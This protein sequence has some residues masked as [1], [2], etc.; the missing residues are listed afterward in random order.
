MKRNQSGFTLIELLIVIIIISILSL[1]GMVVYAQA[2]IKARDVRRKA[3]V[4]VITDAFEQYNIANSAYPTSV[5]A[6]SA[7]YAN[8]DVPKDPKSLAG[9]TCPASGPSYCYD[10][11]QNGSSCTASG[12]K[13]CALLEQ[14]SS[15]FCKGNRQ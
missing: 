9:G 13:I 2:Q 15:T 3:D 4:I 5:S 14:D 11:A 1:I 6:A 8:A 7:Y 10:C 12:F